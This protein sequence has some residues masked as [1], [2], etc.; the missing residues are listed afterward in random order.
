MPATDRDEALAEVER[1]TNRLTRLVADL[2]AL[3][4]ADAG[5]TLP[6]RP[7]ELD[8]VVLDTFR[9]ARQLV[10]GQELALEPFEPVQVAGD[11]DRLKQLVLILIDRALDRP[12]AR[13]R[14][15]ARECARSGNDSHHP[16]A[17]PGHRR[18]WRC[19]S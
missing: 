4:R 14:G 1:E 3:A 12:A 2:L 13:R 8:M 5:V 18:G 7:V 15:H 17:N 9:M 11:E 19:G 10:T 6:Q 16:A